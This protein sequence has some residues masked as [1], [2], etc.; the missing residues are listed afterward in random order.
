V[1]F[2]HAS[3]V[4]QDSL[5]TAC[6][7]LIEKDSGRG[8]TNSTLRT[9]YVGDDT[10]SSGLRSYLR[11]TAGPPQGTVEF[12]L[13]ASQLLLQKKWDYVLQF[14][15]PETKTGFVPL[16]ILATTSRGIATGANAFFH[17]SVA[18]VNRRGIAPVHLKPCVG[19]AADVKGLIFDE[20]DFADLSNA[21]RPAHL[22]DLDEPL[23]DGERAYLAE[24][25]AQGLHHRYLLAARKPWHRM[26]SRTPAPIWA[27]VFAR[28]RLRF[29]W[30]KAGVYNLTTFHCIY[31]RN[32]DPVF[33]GALV[34]CL[35]SRIVQT[36]SCQQQRVYGGGLRKFEPGDLLDVPVPNLEAVARPTLTRLCDL[37]LR[38]GAVERETSTVSET[39]MKELDEAVVAAADEAAKAMKAAPSP[40]DGHSLPVGPLWE[41]HRHH[42]GQGG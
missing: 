11:G 30:N 4:F 17:L 14:G 6:L 34:A 9:I 1:Y 36:M 10:Q 29:I 13:P 21:D 3:L 23:N 32:R 7:L 18:E 26:E 33:T 41:P 16:S 5:S 20:A 19:K 42:G 39:L 38:L 12:T 8:G 2:S 37:L 35:N 28:H 40:E 24:G 22:V 31:P 15:L 25:E 27:A